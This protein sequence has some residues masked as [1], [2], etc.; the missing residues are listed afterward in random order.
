M[1]NTEYEGNDLPGQRSTGTWQECADLCAAD[2]ACAYWTWVDT[3]FHDRTR[4]K[5]CSL[6]SSDSGRRKTSKAGST[7]GLVSG[8]KHAKDCRDCT[9]CPS[10]TVT[11]ENGARAQHHT[12][13]NLYAGP[14]KLSEE[15]DGKPTWRS[16]LAKRAI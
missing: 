13:D 14:Y 16:T 1:G 5:Q 3:S 9:I 8:P 2:P 11:L 15:I 10:L 6:K 4:H 12:L 7:G